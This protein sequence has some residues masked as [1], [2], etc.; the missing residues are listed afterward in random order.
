MPAIKIYQDEHIASPMMQL[1]KAFASNPFAVAGLWAVIFLLLLVVLGPLLAPYP[2]EMQNPDAILLPPS[3]DALGHVSHFLGTDDLGRDLFSRLLHGVRL[4]F[5]M[6]LI[7]VLCAL[8]VGFIIGSLSGMMRG[9]KSSIL[10]HLLDAL[11]SIPSLLLA[12]LVVA[13]TGPGLINVFWAVGLALTPQFVRAIH[14]AVHEELQKE[15]VIAAKLDGASQI[16][17]F[18]YVIMPNVWEVVI[19]QTTIAISVAILDIAAL[20]FL[21]LGAQAP[22]SEWGAMIFQGLNSQLIAPWSITIPGLAILFTV[23]SINLVGDGLRSALAPI[24]N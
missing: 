11:L 16:Q 20:G 21:N 24:R 19:I 17:I 15:Y 10:G 4:T 2:P 5:G 9:L 12:I 13:V 18:W 6:S 23:L 8:I 7:V 3:W 14:Q 1:W 22:S